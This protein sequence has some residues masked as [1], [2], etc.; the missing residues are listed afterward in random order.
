MNKAQRIVLV[1]YCFL[2]AYCCIWIPW[3]IV[4]TNNVRHD[5]YF[6]WSFV[7]VTPDYD[8]L[9]TYDTPHWMSFAAPEMHLILLRIVAVTAIAGAGF[10]IAS[11]FSQRRTDV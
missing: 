7:W 9:F 11:A 6:R 5:T 8:S 3:R 2:L 10:I 4:V 1:I